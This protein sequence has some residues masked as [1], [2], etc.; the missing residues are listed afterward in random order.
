MTKLR[1]LLVMLP[2]FSTGIAA[3]DISGEW[4]VDGVFDDA[5]RSRGWPTARAELV[6][7]LKLDNGKVLGDCKPTNAAKGVPVVGDVKGEN[8][9]W[10]FEIVIQPGGAP[11]VMT[12]TGRLDQTQTAARG[13]FAVADFGGDFTARRQ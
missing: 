8:I 2:V 4:K 9:R 6:C 3:A 10:Q 1:L 13:T 12:Y 5:S 11:V 7:T